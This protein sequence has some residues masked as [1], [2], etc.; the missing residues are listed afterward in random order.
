MFTR[1]P[2][3][4]IAAPDI[5]R[6]IELT[7][8]GTDGSTANRSVYTPGTMAAAEPLAVCNTFAY[9]PEGALEENASKIA[10]PKLSLLLPTHSILLSTP[11]GTRRD[12]NYRAVPMYESKSGIAN[13]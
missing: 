3:N 8:N 1:V 13:E 2:T 9:R 12:G 5:T 11:P 10:L 7:M 4:K 6:R